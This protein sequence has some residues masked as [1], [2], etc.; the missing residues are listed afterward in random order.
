MRFAVSRVRPLDQAMSEEDFAALVDS[1]GQAPGDRDLLLELMHERHPIYRARSGDATIRMRG[2]LMAAFETAG[3]PDAALLFVIE[4]LESGR[5]AYL[6]AAA[7]KALR[8]LDVPERRLVPFLFRAIENIRYHDDM[9]TFERIRPTWPA[10][11]PTTALAEIFH[12]FAWVGPHAAYAFPRLKAL[13][14][15][16]GQWPV[17]TQTALARAIAAVQA[18]GDLGQS[19]CCAAKGARGFSDLGGGEIT[20]RDGEPPLSTRFEDQDRRIVKYGEFF[21]GHPTIVVFFYTRCTNPNKCSLTITKLAVLQKAIADRG[22]AGKLGTAAISYDPDFDLAPRL[23]AYGENRSV[24]FDSHNRFLR[25]TA[26][27][28]DV[29][30]YFELD[31]NYGPSTVNRHRIEAFVLDDAG[32][33][34][35]SFTRLQWDPAEV[36]ERA[37]A[38]LSSN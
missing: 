16:A 22:V 34:A 2:Y 24:T 4:E 38:A 12:T 1:V 15:D 26:G 13:E 21:T 11:T 20:D 6:V 10:E 7:A 36:L 35:A 5:D 9:V 23:R 33:I 19:A 37:V 28:H 29:A 3:L 31:V 8:G 32:R 25:A 27:F 30:G 14:A 17:A 18:D